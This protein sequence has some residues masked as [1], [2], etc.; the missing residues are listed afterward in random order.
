MPRIPTQRPLRVVSA[1][2]D[3]PGY[4]TPSRVRIAVALDWLKGQPYEFSTVTPEHALEL[5]E[6]LIFAARMVL[7][8][9]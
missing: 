9:R 7:R 5:A 4:G 2:V 8:G 1:G 6:Q 3:H